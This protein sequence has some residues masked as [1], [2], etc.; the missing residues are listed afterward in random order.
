MIDN[1]ISN[2][3]HTKCTILAVTPPTGIDPSSPPPLPPPPPATVG[4]ILNWTGWHCR[5][6]SPGIPG[7]AG[8]SP[9]AQRTA[10]SPL[11]RHASLPGRSLSSSPRACQR[12]Y[13]ARPPSRQHGNSW[14][15]V[16]SDSVA[17]PPPRPGVSGW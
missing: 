10:G 13:A 5:R 15:L 8:P 17:G 7:H 11:P 16:A 14:P 3:F 1:A 9:Q 4:P 2:G 6:T 12:L